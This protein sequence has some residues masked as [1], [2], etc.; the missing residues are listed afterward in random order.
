MA[1]DEGLEKAVWREADAQAQCYAS[2]DLLEGVKAIGEKRAP[3]YK[4]E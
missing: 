1:Q 2:A 4:N 3:T